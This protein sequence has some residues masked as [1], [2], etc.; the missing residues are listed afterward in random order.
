MINVLSFGCPATK[1]I[2]DYNPFNNNKNYVLTYSKEYQAIPEL[3]MLLDDKVQSNTDIILFDFV[4]M[5]C[6]G[7][8][9]KMIKS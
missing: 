4:W 6:L 1:D 7:Q 5:Q 9:F 8:F 2:L 3:N